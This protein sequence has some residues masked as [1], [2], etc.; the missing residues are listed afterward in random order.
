MDFERNRMPELPQGY[1]FNFAY[2][3]YEMDNY[4]MHEQLECD[5]NDNC[6][7]ITLT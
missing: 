3:Q 6:I 2:D 7:S 1:T 5:S 4:T